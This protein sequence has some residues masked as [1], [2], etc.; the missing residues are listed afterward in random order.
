MLRNDR[1]SPTLYV[2]LL[3]IVIF[4][5]GRL[6]GGSLFDNNWSFNHW[7]SLSG[8]YIFLWFS[9][10]VLTALLFASLGKRIALFFHSRLRVVVAS[11]VLF[12]L[13]LLFQFDSFL[14]GGGNLRIAQVAQTDT[15]IYRWFE[16]GAILTVSWLNTFFS[17]FDIHYN[18][19][20][21]YAWKVFSF[22]CTFLSLV[23]ALKLAKVLTADV[24]SRFCLFL[25]L[26]FGPH[27]I[28]H[29]GFVGVEPVVVAVSMWFA[30]VAIRLSSRFTA[31][32]L[33]ALWGIVLIGLFMHYTSI[34]L[35]PAAV[36]ATVRGRRRQGK[37]QAIALVAGMGSYV[38]L[39][40][41]AYY[42]AGQNLEFSKF[43]LFL[44]GKL[45]HSNY[46]IFSARHIGD[47]L[48]IFLLAFPPIIVVAYLIFTRYRVPT[49]KSNLLLPLLMGLGGVTVV[50]ILDPVHNIVLD[51]PCLTAYLLPLSLA[52]AVLVTRQ[53][54]Q[55]NNQLLAVLAAVCLTF[56]LSYLPSY[57]RIAKADSYVTDYLDKHDSFYLDGCLAFRD[58][59]FYRKELD[60]ANAWEWKLPSKSP[61]YLNLEGV[62]ALATQGEEAEAF[63]TL[64]KIIA[65]NP[66][67][68]EARAVFVSIQMK[69]GRYA[70]AKPQID[71]CLMLE[72]YRKEYLMNLYRYYRDIRS[73]PQALKSIKK[74]LK[75]F[76]GDYELKTDLMIVYYRSGAPQTADSLADALLAADSTLPY[77][78]LIKGLIAER[79]N[80]RQAAISLYKKFV[81][82]APNEP[83]TPALQE[84]LNELIWETEEE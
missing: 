35:L 70:L 61:D 83:D 81:A 29:F 26:F 54:N 74:V 66:Y 10:L 23:A 71:T 4:I 22:V 80:E 13:L 42:C 2:L 5:A 40:E 24:A 25:I 19:A 28:L 56:P 64:Y 38:G 8:W 65:K 14:Y 68:S 48:Q 20:G 69:L 37:R 45:P 41:L 17:L 62:K 57:V 15:V 53:K 33:L 77:P 11:A 18:A 73:Y 49:N 32:R 78:Y 47:M 58:A 39:L 60:E 82:L 84:R 75:I 6:W 30:L 72:P 31:G 7:E 46:G 1:N 36:Y 21:V 59:Y 12:G 50:L 55:G 16:Y 3:V 27:T 79:H 44:A 52:L 9:L 51:Y 67:W 76:P 43:V 63:R 34:Y